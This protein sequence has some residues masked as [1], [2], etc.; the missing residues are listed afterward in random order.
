MIVGGIG[1]ILLRPL[2]VPAPEQLVVMDQK[3][4][5]LGPMQM[6]QRGFSLRIISSIETGSRRSLG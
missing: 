1:V 3:D 6:S 5:G 2:P 4:V